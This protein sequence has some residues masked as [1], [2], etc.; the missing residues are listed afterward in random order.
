MPSI[1]EIRPRRRRKRREPVVIGWREW[2]RLPDFT[3]V[4]IK[5][6]VDT[7]AR[8]SS[9]HAFDLRVKEVD[10][11]PVA[12]FH[13]H[14][15]QRSRAGATRIEWPISSFRRV[16][17]SNGKVE[18]RPVITT[19]L[20]LGGGSWPIEVTLTSRDQMGFRMLLGRAAVRRRFIV[21]AGRSFLLDPE[22]AA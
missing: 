9:L 13:V 20:Q 17:S 4:P 18:N 16:R 10:G 1:Q 8:T 7:G 19:D 11:L 21:D 5:A 6:K 14:P 22:E 2:V 3:P 12:L 15:V